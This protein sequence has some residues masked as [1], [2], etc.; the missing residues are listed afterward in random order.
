[1]KMTQFL[2][3]VRK[4]IK[5]IASVVPID[6]YQ[7]MLAYSILRSGFKEISAV[8]VFDSR[9]RLWDHCIQNQIGTESGITYLEFGVHQGYSIKYFAARNRNAGSVFIGLD[10]FEGLPEDWGGLSKGTFN[11]AGEAPQVDDKRISFIKGWFQNSWP[12]VEERFRSVKPDNSLVVHYDADLYSST[13][14]ALFK[15]D[16]LKRSYLAIFDEFTGHETRAL[17]NYCQAFKATVSF[18]GKTD[19]TPDQVVCRITPQ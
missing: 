17:Y 6:A 19:A 14:F 15:V 18:I 12:E 13:L 4:A 3:P 7:R 5:H 1:M 9:E 8:Q 11:T 2:N 10:S 16:G